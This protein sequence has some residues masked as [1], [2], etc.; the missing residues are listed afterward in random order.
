MRGIR[1]DGGTGFSLRRITRRVVMGAVSL[2]VVASAASYAI[3]PT[4][5]AIGAQVTTVASSAGNESIMGQVLVGKHGA[6]GAVVRVYNGNHLV[7]RRVVNS[8]GRFSIPVNPGKYTVVLER[9]QAH[10][11][12]KVTVRRGHSVF[13]LG[14]VTQKS[15]AFLAPPVIFNY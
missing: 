2:I 10:K 7:A 12:V 8:K 6:A 15:N 9:R 1:Q 14:K 3:A 11:T 13:V 5:D 4:V